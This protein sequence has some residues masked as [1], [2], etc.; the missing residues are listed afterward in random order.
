MFRPVRALLIGSGLAV[1]FAGAAFAH[2]NA[3]EGY[4]AKAPVV[5]KG[6]ISKV[7]W[8]GEHAMIFIKAA[9][10]KSWKVQGAPVTTMKENGLDE[11]SFG[12]N[13]AVTIRGYQSTDKACKPDCLATGKDVS[14][15]GG[16]KVA[17]DGSHAREQGKAVH[18]QLV[19]AKG[20]EH[21]GH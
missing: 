9:D 2:H 12:G 14:F 15:A 18:D 17:L 13:G 4:D 7:D 20:A 6:E 16:L 1:A 10:G 8:S 19:K 5:L 21:A 3:M 11:A